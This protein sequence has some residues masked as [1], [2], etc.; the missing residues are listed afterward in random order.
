MK[1]LYFILYSIYLLLCNIS[2]K[3]YELRNIINNICAL[4]ND[5]NTL[6]KLRNVINKLYK[7]CNIIKNIYTLLNIVN[8]LQNFVTLLTTSVNF[9][10]FLKVKIITKNYSE[11]HVRPTLFFRCS[12]PTKFRKITTGNVRPKHNSTRHFD[13]RD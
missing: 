6:Y 2:K 8:T 9:V 5:V 12:C 1:K 10:T 7:L 3:F 11:G 4:L 13:R